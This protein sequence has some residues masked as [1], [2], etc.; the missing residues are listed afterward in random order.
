VGAIG[1]EATAITNTIVVRFLNAALNE[2]RLATA[3]E[4][5]DGL[6]HTTP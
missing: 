6:A 5:S 1:D 2:E 3:A 4:L